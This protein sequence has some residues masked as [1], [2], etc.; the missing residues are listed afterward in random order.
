MRELD[1]Y[2]GL[3][4]RGKIGRR[5]F[6]GRAAALGATTAIALHHGQHRPQG[7]RAQAGRPIPSGADRCIVG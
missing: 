2:A 5:E 4:K 1:Y 7:R 3:L 6:M